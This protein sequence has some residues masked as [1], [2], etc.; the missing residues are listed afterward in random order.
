M[1]WD[2]AAQRAL[3]S[4]FRLFGKAATYTPAGGDPVEVT[5]V[6]TVP[7]KSGDEASAGLGRA[8]GAGVERDLAT[9]DLRVS[10]ATAAGIERPVSG[11]RLAFGG[12]SYAIRRVE[13]DGDRLTW[14]LVLAPVSA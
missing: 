3:D 14:R 8:L 7:R 4:V 6:P 11:D 12:D 13:L 1:S 9:A 10:E 5:V 2:L